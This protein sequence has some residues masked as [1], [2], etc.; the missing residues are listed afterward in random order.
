VR[1][2]TAQQWLH[3]CTRHDTA[4]FVCLWMCRYCLFIVPSQDICGDMDMALEY[5]RREV[6]FVWFGE[7]D[8][9]MPVTA[10]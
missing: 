1:R 5:A 4:M 10:A 8:D 7:N 2:L 3:V 6:R 9:A